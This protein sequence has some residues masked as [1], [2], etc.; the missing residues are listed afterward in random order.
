LNTLAEKARE[1]R[2][3]AEAPEAGALELAACNAELDVSLEAERAAHAA[4][5]E[6]SVRVRAA[7]VA[8]AAAFEADRVRAAELHLG[9]TQ[10]PG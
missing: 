4:L 2:L 10:L 1:P 9:L 6:A 7:R 5:R 8:Q 3:E